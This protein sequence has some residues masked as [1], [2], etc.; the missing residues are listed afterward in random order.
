MKR[1][2]AIFS[3]SVACL[4]FLFAVQGTMAAQTSYPMVCKGGGEMK[5]QFSHAKKGSFRAFSLAITFRKSPRVASGPDLQPGHCS[6]VDRP[7]S[8]EEPNRLAYSPGTGTDFTFSFEKE[9][10]SLVATE[11]EGLKQI[12]NAVRRG[13]IFHVRCHR[14]QSWFEVDRVGP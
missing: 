6:W 3:L 2:R 9:S 7:I 1:F 12:L 14:K 8:G 13:T 4:V 10:W 11:S 5:A